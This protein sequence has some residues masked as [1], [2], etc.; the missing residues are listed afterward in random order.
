MNT[1][2]FESRGGRRNNERSTE[3][4]RII[5]SYV[6]NLAGGDVNR[7]IELTILGPKKEF[8]HAVVL[9]ADKAL[10]LARVI[11]DEVERNTKAKA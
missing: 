10:D 4:G 6:F 5:V 3:N 9:P 2:L 8:R 11:I 1:I 7:M